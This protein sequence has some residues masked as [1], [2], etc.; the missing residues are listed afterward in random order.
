MHNLYQ[1]LHSLGQSRNQSRADATLQIRDAIRDMLSE[2]GLNEI[3][4]NLID[5]EGDIE[6]EAAGQ[7]WRITVTP[8]SAD[9]DDSV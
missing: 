2:H 9:R 5:G 8:V 1:A 7:R 4:T 6:C 3:G